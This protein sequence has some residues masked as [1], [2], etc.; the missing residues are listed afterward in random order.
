MH[1]WLFQEKQDLTDLQVSSAGTNY[2]RHNNT[3]LGA[4]SDDITLTK[5]LNLILSVLTYQHCRRLDMMH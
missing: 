1:N 5:Y 4:N 3:L 2:K